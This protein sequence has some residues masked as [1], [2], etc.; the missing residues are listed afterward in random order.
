MLLSSVA[1]DFYADKSFCGYFKVLYTGL[2]GIGRAFGRLDVTLARPKGLF[3]FVLTALS[4][5]FSSFSF[6]SRNFLERGILYSAAVA[7]E[8]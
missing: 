2:Q 7:P 1:G 5:F 6:T 8:K 4:R 3:N